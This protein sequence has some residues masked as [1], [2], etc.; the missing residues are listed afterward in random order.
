MISANNRAQALKE[1]ASTY[2]DGDKLNYFGKEF[3][4]LAKTIREQYPL[5][6]GIP[7][8]KSI[9]EIS[10]YPVGITVKFNGRNITN[11]GQ[12]SAEGVTGREIQ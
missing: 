6:V 4:G 11:N 9:G 5:V 2:L 1:S 10:K 8:V 12:F 7:T 3:T